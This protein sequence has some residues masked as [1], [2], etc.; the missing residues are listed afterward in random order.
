MTA[1][2]APTFEH[3]AL[4]ALHESVLNPRKTFPAGPLAE[5]TESIRTAGV[6]Q[7]LLVRPRAGGGYEI[8]AGHRRARAAKAAGL[9]AIPAVVRPMTDAEFL[10][11]VTLENLLREDL[12]ELEE[13]AS[14]KTLM[15]TGRHDV[16]WVA[17]RCGRS[18]K[19]VYDRIKLLELG[20]E[21]KTLLLDQ[22]ITAGHAILLARLTPAEQARV[23]GHKGQDYE[24]GGLFTGEAVV[25]SPDSPEYER[26]RDEVKAVSVRELAGWIDEHVR[27]NPTA[28]DPMVFEDTVGVVKAATEHAEKIVPIT[29]EYQLRPDARD[30]NTRT[31]GP[32]SWKRADGKR[33]SKSCARAVTGVIVVGPGRGEAFK[34]CLDKKGCP[35]HW[36][37]EQKATAARARSRERG[38]QGKASPAKDAWQRTEEKRK[39]EQA[40][41]DAAAARWKKALPWILEAVADRVKKA[42]ARAQG[43]LG[44]ILLGE[45][46]EESWRVTRSVKKAAEYVARGTTAED[47]VRHVAFLILHGE[48][49]DYGAAEEFPRRAKAFGLDVRK[50]LD[51]VAPPPKAAGVPRG[52]TTKGKTVLDQVAAAASTTARTA[53]ATKKKKPGAKTRAAARRPS[54]ARKKAAR[55]ARAA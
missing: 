47:L 17:A 8:A 42:P 12:T 41:R 9:T 25:L 38:T 40:R 35:V 37:A 30:E 39:A 22:K 31:V 53:K 43:L 28:A 10:E 3:V 48:A 27:L 23:I 15:T 54:A 50:I 26:A 7:P 36:A 16:E 5:L 21:A 14:Y 51:E 6:L 20:K 52:K 32:M 24:D 44:T 45:L 1:A 33:G 18:V 2:P 13:A 49:S 11:A 46:E 19:Y 34:V 4:A 29:H 55:K